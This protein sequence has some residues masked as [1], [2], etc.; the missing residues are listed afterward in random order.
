MTTSEGIIVEIREVSRRAATEEEG[1][2]D[3]L[4]TDN[5]YSIDGSPKLPHTESTAYRGIAAR[6]NHMA[7]DRVDLQYATKESARPMSEPHE[8]PLGYAD[9]DRQISVWTPT[10]DHALQMAS[11]AESRDDLYGLGLGGM[12]KDRQEHKRRNSLLGVPHD[13]ELFPATKDSCD[14]QC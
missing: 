2:F 11:H 1:H 3:I 8:W 12:P 6:L 9:E 13:Q 4:S 7:S 5:E 14:E 10:H